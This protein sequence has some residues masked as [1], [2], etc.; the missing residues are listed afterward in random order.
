M[1]QKIA[2]IAIILALM[3]SGKSAALAAPLSQTSEPIYGLLGSLRPTADALYETEFVMV[4]QVYPIV[5]ATPRLEQQIQQISREDPPIPVKVWGQLTPMLGQPERLQIVATDMMRM[6]DMRPIVSSPALPYAVISARTAPIRTAP[7]AAADVIAQVREGREF[8]VIARDATGQWWRICCINNEYGWI[9]QVMVTLEGDVAGVP[10]L[11][12]R[13][14][15]TPTPRTV[16][17]APVD[18]LTEIDWL[19]TFFA[20][21]TLSGEPAFATRVNAVVFDW[22]YRSP[23][24]GI[25]PADGFS[26]RFERILSLPN[27]LYEFSVQADDGVR[28]WVDGELMVDAWHLA[29]GQIYQF[30]RDLT[31]PTPVRIDYFEAGGQAGIQFGYE[32][33]AEFPDWQA[34]YF[35]GI[36]PIGGPASIQAEPRGP[37]AIGRYWSL[38]S[39]VPGVIG[40]DNWSVRWTGSFFF[41]GGDYLFWARAL[42]G[43]RLWID[44]LLVLDGWQDNGGYI[45]EIFYQ[46]GRGEHDIRVEYYT[47]GGIA[48]LEVDWRR[49]ED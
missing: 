7:S 41:E 14:A 37:L 18:E 9:S 22:E 34:A 39:P 43:V 27:G 1:R 25:L 33:V 24:P 6:D 32:M 4:A 13:T 15:L 21:R 12:P 23:A 36:E 3:I 45:E 10:T 8:D 49:V 26:A 20:N 2:M 40:E 30:S 29:S 28:V 5:G 42:G 17:P 47:R 46:V 16:T 38:E 48:Q 11:Q 31:G 44:D 19:A 35:N